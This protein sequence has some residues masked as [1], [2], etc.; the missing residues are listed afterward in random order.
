[1]SCD[2]SNF[3]QAEYPVFSARQ[4]DKS[5][6][7]LP[8]DSAVLYRFS[9]LRCQYQSVPSMEQGVKISLVLRWSG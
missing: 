2:V 7:R 9:V 4:I 1:M 6:C 5:G 8:Y 3:R